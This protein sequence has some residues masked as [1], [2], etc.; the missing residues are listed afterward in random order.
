MGG[1]DVSITM[2]EIDEELRRIDAE[3]LYM[4][5]KEKWT[6]NDFKRD[7]EL[8]NRMIELR[9]MIKEYP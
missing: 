8:F 9:K 7:K 6:E 1:S 5:T 3:K 2:E 4:N